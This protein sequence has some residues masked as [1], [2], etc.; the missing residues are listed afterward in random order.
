[1]GRRWSL[2]TVTEVSHPL[3]LLPMNDGKKERP[4][5]AI[6]APSQGCSGVRP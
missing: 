4:A 2:P 6:L 1:V 5:A 3:L